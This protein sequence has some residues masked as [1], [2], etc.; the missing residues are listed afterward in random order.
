MKYGRKHTESCFDVTMR[1]FDGAELCKLVGIYILC[2][3]AKLINKNDCGLYRD[4][5]LPILWNVNGQQ[6][7]RMPENIIQIFKYTGF[8]IELETNLKIVDFLDITF[9]L[10]T[11]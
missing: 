7:D 1:S 2:F 10:N 3:L 5:R 6:T 11:I 9:N 8:T 4:D